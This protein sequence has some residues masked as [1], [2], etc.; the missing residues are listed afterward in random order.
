MSENLQTD[1]ISK[2]DKIQD[3]LSYATG[4]ANVPLAQLMSRGFI[5]ENTSFESWETLLRTAGVETEKDLEKPDFSDFVKL[6]TRF[7]DWEEMLIHSANQYSL[8]HEEKE[9]YAKKM[10]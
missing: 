6:H 3:D 2:L 5:L 9:E 8:R 1:T 10:Y 4:E 7:K